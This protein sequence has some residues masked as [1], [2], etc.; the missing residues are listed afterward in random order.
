MSLIVYDPI[1][2]GEEFCNV[3]YILVNSF[4]NLKITIGYM[5]EGLLTILEAF[6]LELRVFTIVLKV[7]Y[8]K[9]MIGSRNPL[10]AK[11][12]GGENKKEFQ[13][14]QSEIQLGR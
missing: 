13:R 9:A 6:V 12:F 7:N 4:D 11:K 3:L 14:K 10:Q 2:N 8:I 5:L 1:R